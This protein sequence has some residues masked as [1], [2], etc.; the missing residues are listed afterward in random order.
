MKIAF[1]VQRYGLDINGGAELHCRWVAEHMSR[2]WE[3]EVLT[4]RA[5]DYVTWADHYPA[6]TETINGLTVRRFPV[7]VP[8]DPELFGRRQQLVLRK[9]TRKKMSWTGSSPKGRRRPAS[10]TSSGKIRA[11]YDYFVFFSYRYWHSYWGIRTVP[12]KAILVPTAERDAVIDLRFFKDLFRL[13]RAFIY[14]SEE[15]RAMIQT[16]SGTRPSPGRSWAWGP[17][18]RQTPTPAASGKITGSKNPMSSISAG[19]TRT[20]VSRSC[21]V[22]SPVQEGDGFGR[23]PRSDRQLHSPHP[24]SIRISFPS[25]SGPSRTNSTPWPGPKR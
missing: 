20:R 4:T 15:E 12:E 24:R 18:S 6:E 9:N 16:I 2:H 19:S 1:V 7:P 5:H 10:C 13:P 22:S 17:K 11:A 8:R 25:V 23:R 3:V 21:S 14:N